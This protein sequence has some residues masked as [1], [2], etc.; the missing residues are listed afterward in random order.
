MNENYFKKQEYHYEKV[1]K[2]IIRILQDRLHHHH[3]R[4]SSYIY[5]RAHKPDSN[6]FQHYIL[7]LVNALHH[8]MRIRTHYR[9]RKKGKGGYDR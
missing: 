7:R 3:D 9:D 1:R 4:N 2:G 6:L 8:V 5:L